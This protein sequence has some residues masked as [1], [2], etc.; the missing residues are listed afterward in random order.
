MVCQKKKKPNSERFPHSLKFAAPKKLFTAIAS[1]SLL[2]SFFF[3]STSWQK[4][5][6]D[7]E[8]FVFL[9]GNLN[10]FF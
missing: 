3:F 10:F 1:L 2:E 6:T 4:N 5:E 7:L 8:G 9:N